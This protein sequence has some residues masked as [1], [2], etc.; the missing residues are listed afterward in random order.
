MRAK[1]AA[2]WFSPFDPSEV[3]FNYTE[4]NA[5]QYSMAAPQAIKTLAEIQGGADSLE[6]W[7]DRLFTSQ[8]KLS[9]REQSDITG[10][11]GQY[12]HGNEPSHH[13]AYLYNYTNSPH[14]TQ[15][16]VDKITK[17]LYSNSPDGLSGNED[18]GQ[19]SAWYVFSSLGFYPVTPG[20]NQYIIGTPLFPKATI[21]LENGNHFT[22]VA[23]DISSNNKYIES[24]TLNGKSLDR[25]FIYHNEIVEGGTLEFQMTDNP[26]FWGS[27]EG[28]EPKTE[29]TEH[30]ITPPPFIAKG[31]VPNP[32]V[33]SIQTPNKQ[34]CKPLEKSSWDKPLKS[35]KVKNLFCVYF[36]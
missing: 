21:N 26:A 32:E 4:A 7:L 15:F 25:T 24:A 33:G 13:M 28:Q 29:I 19:M 1:R 10:L 3:N 18:C 12:A 23:H 34:S 31:N 30:L 36:K 2:Q 8:S 20:S 14:K 9:G 16:Y 35:L 6:S 27:L 5:F 22:I 11:I 17:E